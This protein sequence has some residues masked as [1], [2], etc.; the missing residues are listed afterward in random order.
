MLLITGY[1]V[2]LMTRTPQLAPKLAGPE[3]VCCDFAEPETLRDAFA[4]ASNAR[5]EFCRSQFC[6]SLRLHP[7]A[8]SRSR[9][10]H[11]VPR[12]QPQLALLGSSSLDRA[13][14][15]AKVINFGQTGL[16]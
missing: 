2:R 8:R 5:V 4:G 12:L 15:R 11:D 3:V 7:L 10:L 13:E 16:L 6:S 14:D 1:R 9:R